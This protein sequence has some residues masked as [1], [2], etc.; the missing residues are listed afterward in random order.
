MKRLVEEFSGDFDVM[1]LLFHEPRLCT[2]HELQTV[3]SLKDFYD[4]LEMI[5]AQYTIQ[6]E[7]EKKREQQK[8]KG[9]NN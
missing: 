5:D 8:P 3:Y 6:E 1:R 4:M 2:L 7:A 9:K